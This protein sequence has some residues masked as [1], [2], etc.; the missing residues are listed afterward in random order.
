MI[1][2]SKGR[3]KVAEDH[4]FLGGSSERHVL[5]I[6]GEQGNNVLKRVTP[7]DRAARHYGYVS[8]A[9]AVVNTVVEG[10]I[11]SYEEV[12]GDVA[13]KPKAILLG[14]RDV[15]ESTLCVLPVAANGRAHMVN[16][17]TE[18]RRKYRAGSCLLNRGAYR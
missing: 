3:E 10:G 14:A 4:S 7:R 18:R 8:C 12:C 11:L 16:Q 1:G 5:G 2:S 17:K 6:R 13:C 15:A 9:G